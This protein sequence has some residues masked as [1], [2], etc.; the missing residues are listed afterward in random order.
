MHV[1]GVEARAGEHR[2]HLG[3]AVDALLAQHRDRG[4]RAAR[5]VGR[6]DILGGIEAQRRVQ[7]RIVLVEQ[8]ASIPRARIPDCR[9]ATACGR[10]PRST[11]GAVPCARQQY[12]ARRR[13]GDAHLGAGASER[14]IPASSP[15]ARDAPERPR[16]AP[17]PPRESAAPRRAPRRSIAATGSV[18]IE[19]DV[20][21]AMPGERHLEQRRRAGRR[22]SGRDRRAR[23][24]DP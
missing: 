15:S 22:R 20:E 12:T 14:P 11:A 21:A 3:L 4:P 18:R 17:R 2:R 9:A 13:H 16:P 19:L 6:G 10:R 1:V 5:D 23:D 24:P 7:P 8:P